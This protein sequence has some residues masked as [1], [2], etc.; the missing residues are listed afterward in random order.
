MRNKVP[1][2]SISSNGSITGPKLT[3]C[4]EVVV[5]GTQWLLLEQFIGYDWECLVYMQ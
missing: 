2:F 1:E 4:V 3:F 5:T